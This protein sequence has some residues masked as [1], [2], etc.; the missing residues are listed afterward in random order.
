M[1]I[2]DERR[3][4]GDFL[5]AHRERLRPADAGQ[6]RRTPGLR[7]EEL[8]AAAGIS[9]TWC[10][11]IEQGRPVQASPDALSRIARALE[12]NSAERA[13]LF[14]LAGRTDPEGPAPEGGEAPDSL[15]FLVHAVTEPAYGLD[16]LWNA[17]C[18]NPAA[19]RLFRGWLDVA[20]DRNLLRFVFLSEAAREILP[21]WRLRARRLLAEFR[22][23]YGRSFRDPRWRLLVDELRDE[24][25][26]FR[27]A[28]DEQDVLAREGGLR[29]FR[30]VSGDLKRFRQHTYSPADHPGHKLVVLRPLGPEER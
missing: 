6:R 11:W 16:R 29:E 7:R 17:C 20:G 5:R 10:A 8:A 23:D 1:L 4:L 21:D 12:L 30:S 14:Q 25:P 2:P 26:E 24:S 22:A 18:W 19:E 9:V 15:G 27:A 28:W 3:L 13:Y